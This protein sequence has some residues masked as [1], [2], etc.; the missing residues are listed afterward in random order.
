M[1]RGCDFFLLV[2]I[3]WMDGVDGWAECERK[4]QEEEMGRVARVEPGRERESA[5][6]RLDA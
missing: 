6:L 3:I 1:A 5:P 4:K 2:V